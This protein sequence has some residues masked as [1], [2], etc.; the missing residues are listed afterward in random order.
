MATALMIRML[1]AASLAAS[2]VAAGAAW[3][4][5]GMADPTRP[6]AAAVAPPSASAAATGAAAGAA[7]GG[8]GD[9]EPVLQSVFLPKGWKPAALISGQ[10]MAV[11]DKL[12]EA[13]IWRISETEVVLRGPGGERHLYLNPAVS[14]KPVTAKAAHQAENGDGKRS[15]G[16]DKQ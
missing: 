15:M 10:R 3:A 7:S 2:L 12:G 14:M 13:R 6:P 5:S 4:E 8:A 11:G 1:C 16:R 9:G